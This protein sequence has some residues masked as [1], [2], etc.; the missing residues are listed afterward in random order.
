MGIWDLK[1]A[2]KA[3]Y[4][5]AGILTV[6]KARETASTTQVDTS[7]IRDHCGASTESIKINQTCIKQQSYP[8]GKTINFSR[9]PVDRRENTKRLFV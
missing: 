7:S 6:K 8:F 5:A 3:A 9:R 4:L 1:D 2:R